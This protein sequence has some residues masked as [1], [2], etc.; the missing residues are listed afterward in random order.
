MLALAQEG[1]SGDEPGECISVGR[2]RRGLCLG[3]GIG[4]LCQWSGAYNISS[5]PFN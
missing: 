4:L 5:D 1:L 2:H 3:I